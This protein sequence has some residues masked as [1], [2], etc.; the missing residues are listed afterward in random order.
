[1]F[2]AGNTST[3][4]SGALPLVHVQGLDVAGN[5][6]TYQAWYRDSAVFCTASTFNLTN[7]VQLTWAP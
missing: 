6:R 7:G 4:P 3:Y 5:L 2:A 1:V